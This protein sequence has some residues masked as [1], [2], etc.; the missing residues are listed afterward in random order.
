MDSTNYGLKNTFC[1]K[2]VT[3]KH[4]RKNLKRHGMPYKKSF[5]NQ[6]SSVKIAGN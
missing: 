5:F 3:D 6:A 2:T 4:K 1:T